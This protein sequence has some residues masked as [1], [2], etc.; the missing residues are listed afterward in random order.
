[1]KKS[2]K[3]QEKKIGSRGNAK[4]K[5][6]NPSDEGTGVGRRSR[7]RVTPLDSADLVEV[8]ACVIGE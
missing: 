2:Q 4:L 7:K 8:P 3:R 6:K 1:M 5:K